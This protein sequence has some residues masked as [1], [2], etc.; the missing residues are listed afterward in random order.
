MCASVQN[1]SDAL[2]SVL[3]TG[4]A[5]AGTLAILGPLYHFYFPDPPD[6]RAHFEEPRIDA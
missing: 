6:A 4:F 5:G 3:W 2:I 1:T